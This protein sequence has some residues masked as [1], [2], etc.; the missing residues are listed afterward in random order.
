MTYYTYQN[1]TFNLIWISPQDT[2]Q[3]IEEEIYFCDRNRKIMNM[4]CK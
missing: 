1:W 2:N 3:V 4:Y